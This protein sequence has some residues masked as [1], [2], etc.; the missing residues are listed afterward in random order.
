[1][2]RCSIWE[3]VVHEE[4]D[5]IVLIDIQLG[6][7]KLSIHKNTV[8]SESIWRNRLPGKVDLEAN[9]RRT[10]LPVCGH[11]TSRQETPKKES[12]ERGEHIKLTENC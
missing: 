8:A 2:H 3:M 12:D 10:K 6:S 11:H 7:R 5:V 4:L 9:W 1:M